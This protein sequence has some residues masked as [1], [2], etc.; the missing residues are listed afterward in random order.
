M[1]LEL[2]VPP[3]RLELLVEGVALSLSLALT[4]ALR[5]PSEP[6]CLGTKKRSSAEGAGARAGRQH[7][8]GGESHLNTRRTFVIVTGE[9]DVHQPRR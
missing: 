4:L 5:R 3:A 9:L 7:R 6:Q 1:A 8:L 2:A